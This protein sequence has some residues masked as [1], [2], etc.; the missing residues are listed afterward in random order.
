MK[1][2]QRCDCQISVKSV[3]LQLLMHRV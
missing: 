2:L 1:T 3:N